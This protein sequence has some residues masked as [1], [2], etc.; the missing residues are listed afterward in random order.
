MKSV[1][2]SSG[3]GDSF[4]FEDIFLFQFMVPV[5][6]LLFFF[7]ILC[8]LTIRSSKEF[9]RHLKILMVLILFMQEMISFYD[10]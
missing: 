9:P 10:F 2:L 6:L 3:Y 8:D 1:N 5:L 4:G 7:A